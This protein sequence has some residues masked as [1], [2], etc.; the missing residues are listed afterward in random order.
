MCLSNSTS[1]AKRPCCLGTKGR[2]AYII[3]KGDD[4]GQN[5]NPRQMVLK[6]MLVK[7][8]PMGCDCAYQNLL[9]PSFGNDALSQPNNLQARYS[10]TGFSPCQKRWYD[11]SGNEKHSEIGIGAFTMADV[12]GKSWKAIQGGAAQAELD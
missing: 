3:L 6:E 10:L 11:S 1:T 7:Y 5:T 2:Y 12:A 4:G 8:N 9:N